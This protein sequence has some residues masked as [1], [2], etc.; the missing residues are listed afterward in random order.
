MGFMSEEKENEVIDYMALLEALLFVAGEPVSFSLITD[1]LK[2]DAKEATSII[3]N[4]SNKYRSSSTS[5]LE[6]Q[7][8]A[9]GY[10]ICT[11]KKYGSIL[12]ERYAEP[13]S[14][15]GAAMETL[16]IVAF[17][18]P[19]TRAEIE[20]IRGVGSERSLAT[21]MER[22]LIMEYGRADLPGRP[23]LY[24]VTPLFKRR[25]GFLSVEDIPSKEVMGKEDMDER[26]TP[27]TD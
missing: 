17:K 15:S 25:S 12:K 24:D 7:K 5:G 2:V 26:T 10:R 20:Q 16:A 14:L 11:K 6:L 23:I 18:A 22:D 19:V 9:G 13:M 4:L 8:V 3:E 1:V 27:K 21:L